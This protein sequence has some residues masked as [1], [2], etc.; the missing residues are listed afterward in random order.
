MD[1]KVA[2]A[3]KSSGKSSFSDHPK[4][5]LFRLPEMPTLIFYI[6]RK[7]VCFH[8]T[9]GVNF[10]GFLLYLLPLHRYGGLLPR[11]FV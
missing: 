11:M 5:L 7:K 3:E 10:I 8:M 4:C 1:A 9:G 6:R 2:Q